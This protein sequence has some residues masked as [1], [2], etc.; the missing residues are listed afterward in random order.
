MNCRGCRAWDPMC[1]NHGG[2]EYCLKSRT[3]RTQKE[4]EKIRF[5]RT[6]AENEKT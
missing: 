3:Y 4:L 1:R 5:S 2:C 6:D